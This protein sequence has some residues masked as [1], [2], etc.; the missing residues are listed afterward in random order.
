MRLPEPGR[1]YRDV[2]GAAAEEL[3]EGLDMLEAD[4]DLEG[5]DVDAAAPDGEYVEW[6]R[7]ASRSALRRL[8]GGLRTTVPCDHSGHVNSLS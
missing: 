1:G 3:A 8:S 2:G 7:A 4:A 5:I 6:L